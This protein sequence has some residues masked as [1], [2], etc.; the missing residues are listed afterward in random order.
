MTVRKCDLLYCNNCEF[1]NLHFS[2]GKP[3]IGDIES[4]SYFV[5]REKDISSRV[6]AMEKVIFNTKWAYDDVSEV[7]G[8]HPKFEYLPQAIRNYSVVERDDEKVRIFFNGSSF[9]KKGGDLL[10]GAINSL[11][12][13]DIEVVFKLN[14]NT[15]LPKELHSNKQVKIITQSIPYEEVQKLYDDCDIFCMPSRWESY[16]YVFLEAMSHARPIAALDFDPM[17]EV[18]GDAGELI[19]VRHWSI[20]D[21]Y[22]LEQKAILIR[23]L[24]NALE[25]LIND[26]AK[27][28]HLGKRGKELANTKYSLPL[29]QTRFKKICEEAIE[30]GLS[31]TDNRVFGQTY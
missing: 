4:L 9:F 26:K 18:I 3:K 16:G 29:F 17:G 31:G 2:K 5:D 12:N 24:A 21:T 13:Y 8:E 28:R 10:A 7:I 20:C 19:D 27:R 15:V 11:K 30:I 25:K 23:E 1:P 14:Q 22:K 6:N